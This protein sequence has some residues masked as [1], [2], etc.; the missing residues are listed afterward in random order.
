VVVDDDKRLTH[1][2]MEDTGSYGIVH[3]K[4]ESAF[5]D[6]SS[7]FYDSVHSVMSIVTRATAIWAEEKLLPF[8]AGGSSSTRGRAM[9]PQAPA[10]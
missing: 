10:S 4:V 5:Y 7:D 6:S 8:L 1:E 3:V 9:T 2:S